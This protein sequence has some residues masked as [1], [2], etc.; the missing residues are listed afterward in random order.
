MIVLLKCAMTTITTW[1]LALLLWKAPPEKMAS[2]YQ[3]PGHEETVDQKTERYES[4]ARDVIAV[5]YD[6]NEK[7]L[8][9]GL[10]GRAKT[11]ATLLAIGFHESGFAH[12]VD[13]GPC[14]RGIDKKGGRCDGGASACVMQLKI[15][16][17]TTVEGW[18]QSD[19]FSDRQKCFRAA[20]HLLKRS[21]KACLKF[22][23][24]YA[25]AAYAG[26]MC[27]FGHQR[28]LELLALVKR[29]YTH[30][31]PPGVDSMFLIQ[32]STIVAIET[33]PS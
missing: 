29:F 26:G 11:A 1:A 20:L 8:Y 30:E 31:A 3:L 25:F 17:G 6:A 9:V 32:P 19:L 12:D 23:P 4:I 5:A 18:T 10:H 2:Q 15:G 7:P 33:P 24:D 16:T 22:G 21:S 14:Y 13:I 28:G 27:E